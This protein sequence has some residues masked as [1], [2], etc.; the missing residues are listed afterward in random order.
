MQII[1]FE[2]RSRREGPGGFTLIELLVVIAIIAILAALLLPALAKA[3]VQAQRIICVNHLK[4]LSMAWHMY[5]GDFEDRLP[6]NGDVGHIA[7]STNDVAKLKN[8]NWVHGNMKSD[9]EG[10]GN[11]ELVKA[12]SLFPYARHLDL[13]KC[14]A[15]KK[16][17]TVWNGVQVPKT[18]S[19]SM[20]CWINPITDIG[21]ISAASGAFLKLSDVVKPTKTWIFI[22][23][24][25]GCI[26]DG[27]FVCSPGSASWT[28]IPAA[29]H[30]NA[31]GVAFADYHAEI[32]K[33]HDPSILT[34]SGVGTPPKENPPRD[35]WWLEERSSPH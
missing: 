7:N 10:A 5:P 17:T 26:N 14:P 35:L 29:Y 13:Y 34:P 6:P 4:Q 11:P 2:N 12:G 15:D 9:G 32:R 20:N 31:G 1:R 19:R 23:E 24:N 30:N 22:D 16:S 3:K 28:D 8:G 33:W 27:F 21:Y 25:P 18:R